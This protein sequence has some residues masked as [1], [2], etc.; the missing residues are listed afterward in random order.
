M[1]VDELVAILGFKTEG[2]ADLKRFNEKLKRAEK[3]ATAFGAA[4]GKGMAIAGAAVAAGMSALGVSVIKTNAQFETYLATLETIEG[5]SE[6][7]RKALDWATEFGRT[8]PYDVGQVTEAFVKLK[9]YGIDPMAGTM[10]AIGDTAAAMGKPLMQA[11]EAWADAATGEFE[12]MKEFGM[13]A[14]QQGDQVTFFWTENGKELSKTVKKNATE[15][16]KFLNET[17]ARRFGGA[18]LRQSKTWAGMMSNLGDAWIDFQRK[19]GEA[20][21]FDTVKNRLADLLDT[22]NRWFDDGTVDK[23]AKSLSR[24]FIAVADALGL[25]AGRIK[26]HVAAISANFE[27]FEPYLKS[28]GVAFGLLIIRAFPVVA[29]FALLSIVA[30]DFVTYLEDGESVIGYFIDALKSIIPASE[31]TA[32]AIAKTGTAIMAGLGLAFLLAPKTVGGLLVKAMVGG[33]SLAAAGIA[34][35]FTALAPTIASGFAAAFAALSNPVGW[36]VILGV[37]VAAAVAYFK[38]DIFK[39]FG[40]TDWSSLGKI[41][42]SG[43][44]SG[45]KNMGGAIRDWFA[46]IIPDWAR[47]MFSGGSPA[48][49]QGLSNLYGNL[50]A[51]DPGRVTAGMVNDARRHVQQNTNVSAPITINQTV[52]QA[53]QAPGAAASAVGNAV[54]GVAR[55]RSQYEVEPAF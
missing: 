2:E 13:R 34:A 45:L 39:A 18:M 38:D 6:K 55:Q 14:K 33:A 4:L 35:A 40:A 8:T 41:I 44:L 22:V 25:V 11:V 30:E 16:T 3:Q 42:G 27:R 49:A 21:F 17:M 10:T 36:A 52:T 1:I 50:R 5:S 20:G 48:A 53:T 23:V 31:E 15:I 9:S 47:G 24:S 43:I 12:R 46:S 7:A 19:I 51:V 28:I 37:V 29:A 26:T 32:G 54:S